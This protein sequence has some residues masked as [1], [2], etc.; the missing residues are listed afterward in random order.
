MFSEENS[1]CPPLS[2]TGTSRRPGHP[3]LQALCGLIVALDDVVNRAAARHTNPP[4]LPK[5]QH[6][7]RGHHPARPR[8]LQRGGRQETLLCPL[9][10]VPRAHRRP[11]YIRVCARSC[12]YRM[13][14]SRES[15]IGRDSSRTKSTAW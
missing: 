1:S 13:I 12:S 9:P 14:S 7:L 15:T 6:C 3:S 8:R 4:E 2:A 5:M 10:A 11:N